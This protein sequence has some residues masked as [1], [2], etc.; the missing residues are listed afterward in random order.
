MTPSARKK[1]VATLHV[2]A[3][4]LGKDPIQRRVAETL[5]DA[6][7]VLS[8]AKTKANQEQTPRLVDTIRNGSRVTIVMPDGKMRT[9]R[10]KMKS[11]D[12]D[13]WV[14]DMGGRYGTPALASDD[15]VVKV[16]GAAA[17]VAAIKEGS[18]AT[19]NVWLA[20]LTGALTQYDI[21]LS[22]KQPN[23][24]RLGHYMKAVNNVQKKLGNAALG[25]DDP[26][27][28]EQ[29]I[30]AIESHI[31]LPPAQRTVKMIRAY[32]SDG[33]LPRYPGAAAGSK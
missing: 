20:I 3:K 14:L 1:T 11:R 32:M 16:S 29:L 15:N 2:V 6:A 7:T 30:Q 4:V 9:G 8:A 28:L 24:Y 23:I 21:R 22:R 18:R 19:V 25:S 31:K 26:E 13:G 5:N 10:A 17:K 12:I 27:V 33:K